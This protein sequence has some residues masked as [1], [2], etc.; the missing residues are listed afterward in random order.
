MVATLNVLLARQDFGVTALA[1]RAD[2]V[3]LGWVHSS[4]LEDPSPF[5]SSGQMLLTTGRQF[6]DDDNLGFYERYVDRLRLAGIVALGFG[7]EVIR[8]GTPAALVAACRAAALPLVEV[9]YRT[10]FIALS[11]WVAA[12]QAAEARERVEWA[13]AAQNAVSVAALGTDGI[14]SA[15]QKVSELLDC[16]ID[17]ID[18]DG[19]TTVTARTRDHI[20][21][22]RSPEI[23]A[24]VIDLLAA[25]RRARIDLEL[26][27][28]SA[29]IQTLGSGGH[30]TG[31]LVLQ[32]PHP[33]DSAAN[34]VATTLVALA[35]VSLEHRQALRTS[36]RSLMEQLFVLL[37]DGRVE[38]V[39]KAIEAIPAGIP[40]LNLKV[41]IVQLS[42][43]HPRLRDALERRASNPQNRTFIASTK[44]TATLLIEPR[45]LP[46][47]RGFLSGWSATAGVSDTIGWSRLDVGIVQAERAR[48]RSR[49]GETTEFE[50]LVSASLLGLLASSAVA[51]IARARLSAVLAEQ[52]GHKALTEAGVWLRHNAQWEPAARE[53]GIHRHSLKAR[54]S[55]L[56][57][58][59]GLDL[60]R[61]QDRAELWALLSSINLSEN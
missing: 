57:K 14:P 60:D 6:P 8:A 1:Q 45:Q 32:R 52:G 54:I 3:L 10:P 39:R 61:F 17:L 43:D 49:P 15:I 25:Q 18:A 7:T 21:A 47:L 22:T 44:E 37:T 53:L 56:A 34:S 12:E 35:E 23:Q 13:S 36:L 11:Q 5:V 42:P 59:T 46:A 2:D 4:D 19:D 9:P 55:Q 16:T 26:P 24:E 48:E 38:Q 41:V 33:F 29:I 20:G 58:A 27:G 30:L 51:E 50:D 28:V 31:A 40:G